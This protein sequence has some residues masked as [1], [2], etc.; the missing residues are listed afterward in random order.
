MS[1]IDVTIMGQ[2]Y[3]LACKEEEQAVL[4]QAAAFLDEKMSRFRET[5]KIK[6]TDKIAVIAALSI[7]V[8]LL[9]TRAPDGVFSGQTMA[10]IDQQMQSMHQAMD[11]VLD[12]Q[13]KLF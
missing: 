4:R 3:K 12:S 7:A 8:E 5:T 2:L 11:S 9:A 10:E 13:E 6:S 1:Q